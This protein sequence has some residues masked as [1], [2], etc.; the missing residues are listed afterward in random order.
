MEISDVVAGGL[1]TGFFGFLSKFIGKLLHQR[2]ALEIQKDYN[3]LLAI[4]SKRN[5]EIYKA[6]SWYNE[7]GKD[8]VS[9]LYQDMLKNGSLN[10]QILKQLD[11]MIQ[12]AKQDRTLIMD[13]MKLIYE[14]VGT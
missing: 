14:R 4:S 3:E 8:Q 6:A 13:I 5:E 2:S 1:I 12:D 10:D 11:N 7:T 9:D